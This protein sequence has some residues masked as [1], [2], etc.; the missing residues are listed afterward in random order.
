M[1]I[2]EIMTQWVKDLIDQPAKALGVYLALLWLRCRYVWSDTKISGKDLV[3]EIRDVYTIYFAGRGS[4]IKLAVDAGSEFVD[5]LFEYHREAEKSDTRNEILNQIELEYFQ[6]FSEALFKYIKLNLIPADSTRLIQS[7]L[8]SI[9]AGKYTRP[10]TGIYRSLTPAGSVCVWS[11]VYYLN[12]M[13]S[14]LMLVDKPTAINLLN[15]LMASGIAIALSIIVSLRHNPY[16]IVPAPVFKPEFIDSLIQPVLLRQEVQSSKPLETSDFTSTPTSHDKYVGKAPSHEIL[17]DIVADVLRNFGFDVLSG[18]EME[19]RQGGEIEVDVYATK[20]IGNT[21][22]SV[23]VSCKNW[24]KKVKRNFIDEEFG[25]VI[26]LKEIPHL[27]VIV[28]RELTEL[29]RKVAQADGF[30]IIELGEKAD[31]QNAAEIYQVIHKALNE[32]FTTMALPK[33]RELAER[34]SSI[35][36]N[37]EKNRQGNRR[38][39]P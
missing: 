31:T 35:S 38:F 24:D 20:W 4:E 28:A 19:T 23:Y 6:Q 22:F 30:M 3:R 36:E 32:L 15:T 10:I 17:R 1:R 8:T 34:I 21:R 14:E 13:V 33:L 16:L 39:N 7:F 11:D 29:A 18:V 9:L 27:K 37:L 25:R 12:Y 5:K 2:C 26:N